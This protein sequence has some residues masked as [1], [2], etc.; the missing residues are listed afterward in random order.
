MK[1]VSKISRYKVESGISAQP[2]CMSFMAI[3]FFMGDGLSK[4]DR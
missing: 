3:S 4:M 2:P 1:C